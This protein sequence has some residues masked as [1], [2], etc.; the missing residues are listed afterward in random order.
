MAFMSNGSDKFCGREY[1]KYLY[2][3]AAV[4]VAILIGGYWYNEF[5]GKPT[6]VRQ[7]GPVV[8]GVPAAQPR[9]VAAAFPVQPAG[10]PNVFNRPQG[11][12]AVVKALMPSVVN[13]SAHNDSPPM[14]QSA[15][16]KVGPELPQTVKAPAPD[17]LQ[18][19]NPYSGVS[20]ESIGSGI[21]VTEEGHVLTNFHV[22][23]NS[24][25]IVVMVYNEAGD[26]SFFADVVARD[27]NRDLALLLIEPNNKLKPAPLGN[28]ENAQIGDSVI[29]IGSPFGLN[30]SV[31]KGIVS[32]KRKVVNIGGVLH[33]GLLQTDA[34]INRGNSGGPLVDGQGWV[35]GVN[36][37]I[38]TTTSA[39]AGVGFAVPI[40]TAREFLDEW[41]TLPPVRPAM[42]SPPTPMVGQA[43]GAHIA[44]RPPPP[45]QANA[46]PPHGDRGPC[47]N[48]HDI[49][50]G[51]QAVAFTNVAGTQPRKGPPIP[52]NAPLAHA[53][54]GPCSNCH[55]II[56]SAQPVAFG[57]GPGPGLHRQP[58]GQGPGQGA[59]VGP[60]GPDERNFDAMQ[61]FSFNPGGA[62]GVTVAGVTDPAQVATGPTAGS[63]NGPTNG[64]G[65]AWT[66]LDGARAEKLRVPVP[67]GAIITSVDP[68]L[69]GQ[70]L[71]LRV[72][73]VV[74]KADGRWLK[75]PDQVQGVM[76][77]L[78]RG[79]AVRLLVYRSGT[80]FELD[81]GRMNVGGQPPP[82]TWLPVAGQGNQTPMLMNPQFPTAL[83]P[84]AMMMQQPQQ[85]A[86]Q[87]P[88]GGLNLAEIPA[89]QGAMQFAGAGQFSQQNQQMVTNPNGIAPPGQLN[90]PPGQGKVAPPPPTEFEWMG[91][92]MMPMDQA[93]W[94]RNP[95]MKGKLGG[96]VAD[97]DAGGLAD[98]AGIQR[99]DLVVAINGLPVPS[100]QALDNAIKS[101]KAQT[102][103]LVEIERR[104]Q[105][106]F[107]TL[108]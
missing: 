45:I 22:V 27:N 18:F 92:E 43:A 58:L 77:R 78:Q 5:Q 71:G 2:L 15:G 37:A 26:K 81:T 21:V 102:G 66:V 41:I 89:N 36:T 107:A 12:A 14:A 25:N 60:G 93:A 72:D 75:T 106:M 31:S 73:D 16:P 38:Y 3:I 33:K 24:K 53:D 49:L 96:L 62:I 54:W 1:H 7:G 29:T 65:L 74:L 30:H 4:A 85:F 88:Q 76:D 11:F 46:T 95:D 10:D 64:S 17:G 101:V 28:S 20:Q 87:S 86:A 91:M 51:P 94:Q 59:G 90:Q 40:N 34:A 69:S 32:G 8:T 104:N 19:A 83:Q 50:P 103:V 68:G 44:V 61:Q 55:Q 39:F 48:C 57:V 99:G 6:V 9:N 97:I 79:E 67:F 23:E 80:R 108:Q 35:I 82:A 105:R 52:A 100:A 63:T 56:S 13:I 84:E 47:A 70:A 98:R 42:P